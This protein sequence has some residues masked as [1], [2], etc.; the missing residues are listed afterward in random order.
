MECLSCKKI[1]PEGAAFCPVCGKKVLDDINN[2][3]LINNDELAEETW[4]SESY[5]YDDPVNSQPIRNKRR[6]S[7][8]NIILDIFALIFLAAFLYGDLIIVAGILDV[9]VAFIS[10]LF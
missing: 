5:K 3:L 8:I 6:I 10:N 4:L 1:I 2:N 9:I 7:I